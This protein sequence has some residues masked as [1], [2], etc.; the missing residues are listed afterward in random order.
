MQGKR[1]GEQVGDW[2][3]QHLDLRVRGNAF[4]YLI[5]RQSNQD[6]SSF[7]QNVGWKERRKVKDNIK[8]FCSEELE[9]LKNVYFYFTLLFTYIRINYIS[10][11][12]KINT[13]VLGSIA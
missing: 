3:D 6:V 4:V 5:K 9:L 12:V 8:A 1:Q 11:T 2:C 7:S 10:V 13:W